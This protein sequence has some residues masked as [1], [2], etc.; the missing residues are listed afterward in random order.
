[1]VLSTAGGTGRLI[2]AWTGCDEKAP[3]SAAVSSTAVPANILLFYWGQRSW[4]FGR[5]RRAQLGP[6]RQGRCGFLTAF[7]RLSKRLLIGFFPA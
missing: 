5:T 7:Q 2:A 6:N 1:M 3:G 4:Q